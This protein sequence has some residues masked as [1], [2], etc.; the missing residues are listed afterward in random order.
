M[1]YAVAGKQFSREDIERA[2]ARYNAPPAAAAPSPGLGASLEA[3]RAAAALRA[4]R[5]RDAYI[6]AQRRKDLDPAKRQ[7][8]L[9][10]L[11]PETRRRAENYSRRLHS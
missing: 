11:D 4:R 2:R 5:A 8:D 6:R 7:R 9:A 3:R 10:A 1:L